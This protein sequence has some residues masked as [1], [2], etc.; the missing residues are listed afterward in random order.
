MAFHPPYRR[1]AQLLCADAPGVPWVVLTDEPDDFT[2]LNVRAVLHAPTGPMAPEYLARL[3]P[4]GDGRGGPAYHDKRFAIMAALEGFDTA[5]Y[6]DADSRIARIPPLDPFP[7]GI[8]AL[9]VVL[10]S[11]DEHLKLAGPWR[12]PIFTE[13]A[14]Y[15]TGGDRAL[16]AAPWCHEALLA[17]TKDGRERRF[18]ETWSAAADF[19]QA[20]EVYSGEGGVIG[21]AA[22]CAGWEVNFSAL[23]TLGAEIL[24]EGHGP[25]SD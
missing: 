9:P 19:L 18:F 7:S 10:R 23:D 6:V 20:R 24:H 25:K 5:I 16:S 1:R 17:V 22:F 13:L 11:I 12:R 4:T 15:L 21:L 3:P 14:T 8:A 2:A